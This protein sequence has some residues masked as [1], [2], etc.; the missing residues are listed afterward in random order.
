MFKGL[1]L[2]Q[3]PP[4]EAPLLF[5]LTAPLWLI[6]AGVSLISGETQNF[7]TLHFVTLGFLASI[8]IGALLQML[9]VVVGVRFD[10]PKR[11]ALFIFV[12]FLI[13]L[14][15]FGLAFLRGWQG[16]FLVA[17]IA[18]ATAMILF[19]ISAFWKLFHA[20]NT[21]P[22]VWAMRFALLFLFLATILGIY[23]LLSLAGIVPSIHLGDIALMHAL[24]AALGWIGLLIVGVSF[25]VIP[26][27]YVTQEIKEGYRYTLVFAIAG[28][29]V[30][31]AL[32][33]P[34]ERL[35]AKTLF[36]VTL[37]IFSLYAGFTIRSLYK[38]KRSIK[39]PSIA[40]WY[41]GLA[42][43]FCMPLFSFD[44]TLFATLYLFGFAMSIVI[45]MLYKIV[46]FLAWFHISSRGFFDMPTMKEMLNE[47]VATIQFAIHIATIIALFVFPSFAG[48]LL[49]LDSALIL[50]NT[51]TAVKIYFS[52]KKRPSPFDLASQ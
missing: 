25:Q 50:A 44:G 45:G 34:M 19:S 51:F 29:I 48:A 37:I 20:P 26:M 11:F 46:P 13:G 47:R 7:A 18:L 49:I 27:F 40:L 8:M 16:A 30:A 41:I 17:A 38:R 2:D 10:H 3:A 5:F 32:M 52:Y 31:T 28:A 6:V 21:T 24:F 22:T 9:P 15:S 33:I 1:S 42:T 35:A 4:F 23:M 43:L 14:V 39:E 12:P 36:F